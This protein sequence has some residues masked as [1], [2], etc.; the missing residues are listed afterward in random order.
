MGA[1]LVDSQTVVQVRSPASDTLR[2]TVRMRC[3][4][5]ILGIDVSENKP[6][7][8]LL[9][10]SAV[11]KELYK[12]FPNIP[13]GFQKLVDW[14]VTKACCKPEGIHAVTESAGPYHITVTEALHNASF[15]V[16]VANPA[17][18]ENFA[19]SLGIK[20]KNDRQDAP[21]IALSGLRLNPPAQQPEPSEYRELRDIH[22]RPEAVRKDIRREN[23]R[24]EKT[25][26]P[27][28][29]TPHE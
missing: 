19:G 28:L 17:R 29:R 1:A 14:S 23:N 18:T 2:G 3:I 24:L 4:M 9:R 22:R 16:S 15:K 8:V 13:K 20:A 21:V 27:V 5:N 12:K 10:S 11:D 25:K 26:L 6:D 7:C